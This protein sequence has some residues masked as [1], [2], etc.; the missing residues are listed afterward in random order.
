[1]GDDHR[2]TEI[3]V[4]EFDTRDAARAWVERRLRAECSGRGLAVFGSV[5]RGVY[6]HVAPGAQPRWQPERSVEAMDA[7]V[8]NGRVSWR[9]PGEEGFMK[10]PERANKD[11]APRA[12]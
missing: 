9:R 8:A 3:D 7:T 1:M 5:D 2:V 4:A 11:W 12:C 6:R 10:T